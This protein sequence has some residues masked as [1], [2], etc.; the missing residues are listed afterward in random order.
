M[1]ELLLDVGF[2]LEEIEIFNKNNKTNEFYLV[3][4]VALFKKY[5]CSDLFIKEILINY[6]S[7]INYDIDQLEYKLESIV[8][9]GDNIDEVLID[10]I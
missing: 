7:K 1:K 5:N 8:S 6:L 10:I 9:N 4:L 3:K 2:S